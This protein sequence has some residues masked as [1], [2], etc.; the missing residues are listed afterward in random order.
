MKFVGPGRLFANRQALRDSMKGSPVSHKEDPDA[1]YHWKK[2]CARTALESSKMDLIQRRHHFSTMGKYNQH[3]RPTRCDTRRNCGE[4][5]TK[6]FAHEWCSCDKCFESFI[7]KPP[8]ACRSCTRPLYNYLG[9]G[10]ANHLCPNCDAGFDFRGGEFDT[11]SIAV[12]ALPADAV[13]PLS[14]MVPVNQRPYQHPLRSPLFASTPSPLPQS[15]S[16]FRLCKCSL[17]VAVCG[18]CG[19]GY[20]QRA[21]QASSNS[22]VQSRVYEEVQTFGACSNGPTLRTLDLATSTVTR[23]HRLD[24][25]SALTRRNL[26]GPPPGVLQAMEQLRPSSDDELGLDADDMP[27]LQKFNR[28]DRKFHHVLEVRI[29][30]P[31]VS[32]RDDPLPQ[33]LAVMPAMRYGV[34]AVVNQRMPARAPKDAMRPPAPPGLSSQ[35]ADGIVN[36][37]GQPHISLV[38]P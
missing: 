6:V 17:D 2:V 31:S 35:S 15:H 20:A 21:E 23:A 3:P 24:D 18:A 32:V 8:G 7:G 16:D 13:S 14:A 34:P 25:T 26:Q 10:Q 1:W 38:N 4:L 28:S 11:H 29:S 33:Q 37:N 30:T 19:L 9:P 12:P 5:C 36:I 22:G 27:T